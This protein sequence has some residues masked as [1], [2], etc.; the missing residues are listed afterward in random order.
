MYKNGY[1]PYRNDLIENYVLKPRSRL[2]SIILVN[3]SK[4]K[5]SE[6][7]SYKE[8]LNKLLRL[9]DDEK[10]QALNRAMKDLA[11]KGFVEIL[12]D[13]STNGKPYFKVKILPDIA[14]RNGN[15]TPYSQ[16]PLVLIDDFKNIKVNEI[17]AMMGLFYKRDGVK[18]VISLIRLSEI[19][20][21]SINPLREAIDT[22]CDKKLVYRAKGRGLREP[23]ILGKETEEKSVFFYHTYEDKKALENDKHKKSLKV[24]KKPSKL[25]RNVSKNIN[26]A[27][28]E[29]LSV[30][31][32]ST[33]TKKSKI[34][35]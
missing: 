33:Q 19:C 26:K 8:E 14:T 20:N 11:S 3:K 30:E 16:I 12:R 13:D 28:N 22:L 32:T 5:N 35:F 1:V 24:K 4:D 17:I 2:L 7:F 9:Q 18:N 34:R 21:L 6:V 10:Y 23:F 31:S 29:L 25:L 15:I 27:N